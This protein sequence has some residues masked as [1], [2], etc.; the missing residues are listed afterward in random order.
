MHELF[1]I[2]ITKK[3]RCTHKTISSFVDIIRATG[4]LSYDNNPDHIYP[5]EYFEIEIS[6]VSNN[7]LIPVLEISG[8]LGD[9]SESVSL[10]AQAL[11]PSDKENKNGIK[12]YS[13]RQCHKKAN[14]PEIATNSKF[15]KDFSWS[16]WYASEA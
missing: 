13:R 8:H 6:Q 7:K 15:D 4:G 16:E 2:K 1:K 9:A 11:F 14:Y 12:V 3:D 5:D 10:C